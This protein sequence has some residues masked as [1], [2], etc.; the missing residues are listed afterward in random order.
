[1]VDLE[2]ATSCPGEPELAER[3]RALLP[4]AP[5]AALGPRRS[6]F[7]GRVAL[8]GLGPRDLSLGPGHGTYTRAW[9]ALGPL[10]RFRPSRFILDLHAEALLALLYVTSS[11]FTTSQ[12][13][14]DVDP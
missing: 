1:M 14:L 13:A 10:V 11:G 8:V 9:A 12:S 4:E 5:E 6:H 7:L 2:S 3:L